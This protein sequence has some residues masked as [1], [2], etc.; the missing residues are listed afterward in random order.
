MKRLLL[1]TCAALALTARL[2]AQDIARADSLLTE[3]ALSGAEA[4]YYRAARLRP[5][6]P[7]ARWA[8]GRY[9]ASRGA[10]RVGSVLLEEARKF[11][12]DSAAIARDLAPMY[13]RLGDYAALAALPASSLTA[14]ERQQAAWL[15]SHTPGLLVRDSVTT[16]L[17]EPPTTPASLGRI[18]IRVGG[19]TLSATLDPTR[20]GIVIARGTRAAAHVIRFPRLPNG[21][22]PAVADSVAIGSLVLV[23]AP[24]SIGTAAQDGDAVVG[25]DIMER[26]APTFDPRGARITLR[27]GGKVPRTTRGEHVATVADGDELRVLE[28]R[29]FVSLTRPE[30]AAIFRTHRWTLDAKRGSLI[31]ER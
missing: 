27:A 14:G 23:H 9:L 12:A 20:R 30:V 24:V 19:Q 26:F 4:L 17:Y 16:A 8:L 25:L 2:S 15:A 21:A 18:A 13:R 3:G 28:G 5:H 29:R 22:I 1:I 31:V 6:D 10:V 7:Q 11:G